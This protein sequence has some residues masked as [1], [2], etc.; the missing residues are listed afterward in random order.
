M[1][2][3]PASATASQTV[4]LHP[5][6]KA[7]LQ[8]EATFR[9]FCGGI[10][11]GKTWAG[12]YDLI[13]R[14]KPGRLYLVIAPTY[15]MLSDASFRSFLELAQQLDIVDPGEVKRS[16]PP[17]MR[18]RTGAEVLFRSGDEPDRLRG[19]NISGIWL[20][21]ASLMPMDAFTVA[22]GRLREAREQ[23]WLT[24]TFTPKGRR[25]WTYETFATGRPN[26]ALF[27]A[28]T[29]DNP[30]LPDG[31]DTTVRQQ[32]TAVL[33]AQ[34]LEGQFLDQVGALFQRDWF[35]VVDRAPPLTSRVRGWD[36]AATP[37]DP[38]KAH[39]PDWTA[40]VLLGKD[41]GGTYYV[42]DVRRLQGTPQQVQALVR[43]TAEADGRGVSIWMEQE[44]GSAGVA[45]RDHYLRLLAGFD[46]HGERST[47]SKVDRAVPLAA[48]AEGGTVKLVRGAWNK[49]FLDEV[50]L[51]PFGTHDDIVDS[52]TLAFAHL[53][54]KKKFWIRIDG[55][56]YG[57]NQ[58]RAPRRVDAETG[59]I[60]E[61]S[62][63]GTTYTLPAQH[64]RIDIRPDAPGWER[65]W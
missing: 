41:Q 14:A 20:D 17:S 1:K 2:A 34:E 53:G 26:T 43:R 46:F 35:A 60:V 10:G 15:A 62:A 18:L 32:Y 7:F 61:E 36:L 6:Q 25:H 31:F 12:A 16:A 48:Q 9:A 24:A 52:T 57:G 30:F 55:V 49:A 44:P 47:G 42:L 33:A 19:P 37:K 38:A 3:T 56:T 4:Q 21:E 5:V 39:D 8:S 22:I 28:R 29:A 50:E 40:G 58:T 51:F 27:S 63:M 54:M 45:V 65:L 11:S 13:R 64:R 23:G 59:A